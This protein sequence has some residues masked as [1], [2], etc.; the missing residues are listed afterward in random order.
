MTKYIEVDKNRRILFF[1]NEKKRKIL[2]T[3]CKNS[4]LPL[5]IRQKASV[6]LGT[7]PKDSS[8]VRIKNRCVLT[9]RGRSIFSSF[10]LSRLMLRK[11]ARDGLIPGLKKFN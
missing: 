3:I 2:K 5:S 11:L 9:G 7:L 1:E 4:N 6:A 8:I 10:S